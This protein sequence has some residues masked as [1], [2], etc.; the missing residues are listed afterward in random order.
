MKKIINIAL[1][2]ILLF[3]V[4]SCHEDFL[5]EKPYDFIGPENFYNNADELEMLANSIYTWGHHG[6]SMFNRNWWMIAETPA[7]SITNRYNYTHSRT[8]MDSWTYDNQHAY[9][10][11]IWRY[12][13]EH[14]NRANAVITNGANI[15][16][17]KQEPAG[18]NKVERVIA[19]ARFFR[20]FLYFFVTEFWGDAPLRTEEVASLDELYLPRTPRDEIRQVIIEDLL[21]AESKLPQWTDYTDADKNIGRVCKA[22]AQ[23]MLA[24]VYLTMGQYSEALAKCDA[25]INAGVHGLA[26]SFIDMWYM[27]NPTGSEDYAA[28]NYEVI[29][30]VQ[31]S[32]S[33][34]QGGGLTN[35]MSPRNSNIGQSHWT[36]FAGQYWYIKSFE[37]GDERYEGSFVT[38]YELTGD[39]EGHAKGSIVTY[40]VDSIP[41]DG[42]REDGPAII[43]WLDPDPALAYVEEPNFTFLRYP[44]VLLMKAEALDMLNRT[45]EAYE[46]VNMVRRRAFGLDPSTPSAVADWVV[47][48]KADFRK[49][50]YIERLKEFIMES[51]GTV[52][53]RR[54]WDVATPICEMSSKMVIMQKNE[55]GEDEE[56]EHASPKHDIN[57]TDKFELFPIPVNV[58]ARNPEL[59]QNPGWD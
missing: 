28:H 37:P 3:L 16:D 11:N 12:L 26:P 21:Y 2:G 36:A 23:A 58:I 56:V 22:A 41:T 20:A 18:Y 17:A 51:W 9:M 1:I 32:H 7:P 39:R 54:F 31:H 33:V 53:L 4:S 55:D 15:V 6:S 35:S 45:D 13:F 57:P 49:E 48:S 38:S 8:Q 43:K 10:E 30:D 52:D 34:G 59:S 29:L 25:I 50:L 14:V 27:H 42:Y 46:F 44:D 19:E 5:T 47:G 40:N 24:K